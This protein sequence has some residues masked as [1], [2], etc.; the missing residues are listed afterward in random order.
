MP[1]V[2]LSAPAQRDLHRLQ[3]FLKQ[4]NSL[5]AKKAAETLIQGIRQLEMFP[6]VGRPVDHLSV[7]YQ[8]L[9]VPFG[10]SGYVLL[11]RHDKETDNVVILAVRHQKE[12]G[13]AE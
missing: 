11:F 2:I 3:R 4:K 7:D 13:Y 8:E 10:D 1:Q 6:H 5:A 9:V 12:L